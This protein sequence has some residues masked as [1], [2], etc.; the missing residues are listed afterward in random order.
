MNFEG[1]SSIAYG[2]NLI[3]LERFGHADVGWHD[4]GKKKQQ[5]QATK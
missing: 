4:F 1:Q 3:N 5:E 2:M